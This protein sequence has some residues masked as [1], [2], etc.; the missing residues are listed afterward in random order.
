MDTMDS[1]LTERSH[2]G[3]PPPSL[4]LRGAGRREAAVNEQPPAKH[5]LLRLLRKPFFWAIALFLAVCGYQAWRVHDYRA[6]VDEAKRLGFEWEAEETF[7]LIRRDW[8]AALR[9]ET[10]GT[11]ERVLRIGSPFDNL[12]P[13]IDFSPNRNL[14]QRLRPTGLLIYQCENVDALNGLHSLH[15]LS[16]RNCPTLQNLD[17]LKGLP[18][19]QEL[20]LTDCPALQNLNALKDLTGL[21][22]LSLSRC[23]K[24]QNL[25]A[26]KSLPHLHTLGITLC[27]ELEKMSVLKNFTGLR[28]LRFYANDSWTDENQ[29][30]LREALPNTQIDF[31]VIEL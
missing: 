14:L 31:V 22:E 24:L 23:P 12:G 2:S 1:R 3:S 4:P 16:L 6:A 8:R 17:A 13:T 7:D 18:G 15:G 21:Q 27:P 29:K 30:E 19:L 9:K 20:D 5:P 26:L 28:R 25:D 10:W 11:H